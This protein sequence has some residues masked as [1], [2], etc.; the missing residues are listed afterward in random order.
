MSDIDTKK[1]FELR[2]EINRL[3]DER[4]E[5]KPMQHQID[6]LL[7][8]AGN[9]HNRCAIIQDLMM[10]KVRELTESMSLLL[11]EVNKNGK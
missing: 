2:R 8:T 5:Y 3:L 7:G 6:I 10:S 9:Q 4:P 11:E 1:I